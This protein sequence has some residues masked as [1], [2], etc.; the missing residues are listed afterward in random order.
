ML[1][2]SLNTIPQHSGTLGTK[3]VVDVVVLLELQYEIC[4]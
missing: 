2:P 3:V 4:V 1:S